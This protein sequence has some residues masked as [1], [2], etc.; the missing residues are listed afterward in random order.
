MIFK[1]KQ[2]DQRCSLTEK[3][4]AQQ[5]GSLSTTTTLKHSKTRARASLPTTHHYE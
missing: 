4:A 1:T 3:P 2:L 5:L